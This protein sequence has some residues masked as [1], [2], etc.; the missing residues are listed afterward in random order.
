MGLHRL[1][2]VLLYQ[3]Q[4]LLC[5]TLPGAHTHATESYIDNND[6]YKACIVVF[7]TSRQ[8][9]FFIYTLILRL[10]H[11]NNKGHEQNNVMHEKIIL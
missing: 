11:M 3:Q 8:C 10:A 4:L 7:Y 1:L 2:F 9:F 6:Y 5:R